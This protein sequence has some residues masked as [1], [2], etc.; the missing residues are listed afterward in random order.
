M[1]SILRVNTLTDASSNN[2]TAMS[3]INQGTAKSWAYLNGQGTIALQDSFNNSSPTDH[4]T[5]EYTFNFTSNMGN[6][7]YS[8]KFS[9]ISQTNTGANGTTTSSIRV[10]V[11]DGSNSNYDS[12]Q[13]MTGIHGDLA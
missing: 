2:S 5:G 4:G 8:S 1:A 12:Q 6:A 3:T 9:G 13:V 10:R 7:V 11:R